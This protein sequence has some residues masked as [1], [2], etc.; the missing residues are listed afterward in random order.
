VRLLSPKTVELMTVD[1]TGSLLPES[2]TDRSGSGFG[3]GFE[4][5]LDLGG[6]G[7]H[8]SVGAYGWGG[9]YHTV[10]WVDPAERM[11][12]LLMTQLLPAGDSDLHAKFRALVYQSIVAPPPGAPAARR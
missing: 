5:T 7:R 6:S 9:A 1:H 8:G 11:V 4:V 10:Y 12:A 3:L 2:W